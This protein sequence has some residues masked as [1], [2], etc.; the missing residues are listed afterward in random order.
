MARRKRVQFERSVRI[1]QSYN[2]MAVRQVPRVVVRRRHRR[3]ARRAAR[4]QCQEAR[5]LRLHDRRIADQA[6][7]IGGDRH[8]VAGTPRHLRVFLLARE[9][10]ARQIGVHRLAW[11]RLQQ[12]HQFG[13]G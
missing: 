13:Q 10:R 2:K 7:R 6:E 1:A 11:P 12:A 9:Q 5:A 8:P 3:A 4:P